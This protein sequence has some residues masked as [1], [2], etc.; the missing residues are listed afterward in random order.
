MS[1]IGRGT[2]STVY[3][4][5]SLVAVRRVRAGDDEQADHA[6]EQQKNSLPAEFRADPFLDSLLLSQAIR[7][8][9]R[10]GTYCQRRDTAQPVPGARGTTGTQ[11]YTKSE[12]AGYS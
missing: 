4:L 6:N 11:C 8:I 12:Q 1:L 7:Y 10:V 2:N 3:Q 9:P 5:D